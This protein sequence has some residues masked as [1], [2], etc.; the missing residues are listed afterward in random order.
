[1]R[2]A[3][4]EAHQGEWP[5]EVLCEVLEV[6]RSGYYAFQK[7]PVSER[8]ARRQELVEEMKQVHQERH[9][10]GY[11][12]PRM[13]KELLA[14]GYDVCENTVAQ[15]M[16][17]HDLKATTKKKFRHTTDSNHPYPVAENLLNQEFAQQKPDQ[18]WV[19]DITYIPT[20][21]GWLYLVCVLDLYSRR[22]V[23]WSMAERMTKDLVLSALE[24]ALLRRRPE[25]D[26]MHHSDRGS[27]YASAAFQQLLRDENITCS[28]SR[29]GN[30]YDNA[31]MESFFASLKKE[32]VHQEDYQTR[33]EARQSL[34]EYIEVFYNQQRLHSA[35]GYVSPAEYERQ[36]EQVA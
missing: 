34:F 6:S 5:I 35:L 36:F 16:K 28:M 8:K 20:R 4:I 3:W 12:S 18:V 13:H 30:C 32:L 9:K 29:K 1:V 31:V 26:L 7:R 15:L 33:A 27:Q 21:E 24:M 19:S 17:D 23:G 11:G 10:D 14:K 2:F 22:V 25:A